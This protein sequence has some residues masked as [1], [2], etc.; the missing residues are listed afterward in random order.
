LPT[1]GGNNAT[2]TNP[3]TTGTTAVTFTGNN[4]TIA[5]RFT[6]A[7]PDAAIGQFTYFIVKRNT[8]E[9]SGTLIHNTIVSTSR[10]STATR[11]QGIGEAL[12]YPAIVY[13]TGDVTRYHLA[14]APVWPTSASGPHIVG[15]YFGATTDYG[16]RVDGTQVALAANSVQVYPSSALTGTPSNVNGYHLNDNI[17]SSTDPTGTMNLRVRLQQVAEVIVFESRLNEYQ[18]QLVEGY[19]AWKYSLQASLPNT[20]PY[21]SL[22][23]ISA[24]GPPNVE[25]LA[26][27]WHPALSGDPANYLD[28]G[29]AATGAPETWTALYS[30]G[31]Q[32]LSPKFTATR[33]TQENHAPLIV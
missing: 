16:L 12:G 13:A 8:L 22:A 19:L 26:A 23:P 5:T 32:Y 18:I 31:A 15:A 9:P 24:S 6:A 2:I 14:A 25:E 4:V 17:L 3:F 30:A 21:S 7:N 28:I 33:G 20:H 27:V 29:L 10:S 11:S 1:A